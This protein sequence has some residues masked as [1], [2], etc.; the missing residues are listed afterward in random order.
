MSA[1]ALPP[2]PTPLAGADADAGGNA[3][4]EQLLDDIVAGIRLYVVLTADQLAAVALWVVHTYAVPAADQTPYIHISSPQRACGKT[5]LLELLELLASR[6][7]AIAGTSPSALFRTIDQAEENGGITMLFDEVDTLWSNQQTAAQNED[8][9]GIINNGN[10]RGKMVLRCEVSGKNVTVVP[11][12]TFCPKVLTG[13]GKLPDTIAD[14]S[15]PIKMQKKTRDE[16]VKRARMRDVKADMAP[17]AERLT[18]WAAQVNTPLLYD[19][20]PEIPEVLGDRQ[21]DVSE[22]LLAIADMAGER[23]AAQARTALVRLLD[24]VAGP[25]DSLILRCL[26]DCLTVFDSEGSAMMSSAYLVDKL[27]ELEESPWDR[28]GHELTTHTL[29]WYLKNYEVE[30]ERV[31][32]PAAQAQ[33]RGYKREWF[34]NA[35]QRYL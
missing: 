7:L 30:P 25:D 8:L 21:M 1:T 35:W 33:V 31:W 17:L 29:A 20:R 13:I 22:P 32:Y 15:I 2:N 5:L 6:A 12:P 3:E 24:D 23:W 16:H 11:Y 18:A 4:L 28:Y 14:R 19:A 26:R 27:K 10:R 9:R 34:E